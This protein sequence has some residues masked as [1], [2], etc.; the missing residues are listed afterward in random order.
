MIDVIRD[1]FEKH[2]SDPQAIILISILVLGGILVLYLGSILSPVLAGV[3]IAYVLEGLVKKITNLGLPRIAAFIISY[4][5]FIAAL[6]LILFG[7]VPLVISQLTQLITDF[8]RILE[9][10]QQLILTIPEQYPIFND[11]EIEKMLGSF[12][13]ELVGIGQKLVSVSLASAVDAFTVLVYLVVVPL[14]VFF[15]LKDKTVIINWF[16]RFLPEERGLAYSVWKEVDAK[17]GNYIRGKLLEILIV[18]IATFIPLK[19]MGMNYAATM[20]LL[21]GLSVIIPYVGAVAV[22]IP[23]AMIAWFQ[24]GASSDFVYLM[25]AYTVVQFMDGNVLVPLLFSEVVN[26]HPAAII[27]A[28]L[29]FGGLW[30]VWGVFF[31]I[32]LATLIQAVINSWPS[33]QEQQV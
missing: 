16:R 22:T 19:Y 26:M 1:W 28:V 6:A 9:K 11:Q 13:T 17:M 3:I 30:G 14:L 21:V 2:F 31:A 8:P 33:I 7:L 25:I 5:L 12:S 27:I 10:V 20:S 15:I 24:W 18:G 32:P 29:F 23:V 4:L